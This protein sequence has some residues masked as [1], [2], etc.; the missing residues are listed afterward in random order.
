MTRK[1]KREIERAVADLDT[2]VR[3][4]EMTVVHRSESGELV[5]QRGDP[6]APGAVDGLVVVVAR[7]T[8]TP[9]NRPGGAT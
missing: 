1:N 3:S 5:D 8:R 7:D 6:V 9:A 4:E 2:D